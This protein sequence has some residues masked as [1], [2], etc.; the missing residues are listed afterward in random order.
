MIGDNGAKDWEILG[1][2]EPYFGVIT[3]EKYRK[4]N[5]TKKDIEEFYASGD[6][7]IKRVLDTFMS[8][9]GEVPHGESFDFGCG[10]GRLARAMSKVTG[11]V[12]AYDISNP[13]LSIARENLNEYKVE[14]TE[15]LPD[16][17]FEWVNSY[18]VFQHIKPSSGLCLIRDCLDLVAPRGFVSLHVTFWTDDA[19][20]PKV[21]LKN[22]INPISIVHRALIPLWVRARARLSG[23]NVEHLV[24]MYDYDLTTVARLFDEAEF[25]QLHLSPTNHGG[26]HGYWIHARRAA[27]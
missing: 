24:R 6:V 3:V 23:K 8:V 27:A 25:G 18:I 19:L 14:F 17:K 4:N 12:I 13:M 9:F 16:R 21:S 10:V 2:N 22:R 11:R 20:R 15:K 5:L 7:D 26:H 1:L